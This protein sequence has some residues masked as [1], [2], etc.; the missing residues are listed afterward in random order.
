MSH[1]G[2]EAQSKEVCR[3][4]FEQAEPDLLSSANFFGS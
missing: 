1:E 2:A 4:D 3:E